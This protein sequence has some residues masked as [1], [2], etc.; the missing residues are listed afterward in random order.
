MLRLRT[1]TDFADYVGRLGWV[2]GSG[3]H[4]LHQNRR[5]E[6]LRIPVIGP[7]LPGRTQRGLFLRGYCCKTIWQALK[8]NNRIETTDAATHSCRE[9]CGDESMLRGFSV[10]GVLQQYR[11][12]SGRGAEVVGTSL[13]SQQQKFALLNIGVSSRPSSSLN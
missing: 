12:Q 7:V 5:K 8:R 11:G 6:P 3:R 9:G 10:G 4:Y 2:C 1:S 13:I